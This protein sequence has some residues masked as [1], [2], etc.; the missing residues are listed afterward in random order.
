VK[1]YHHIYGGEATDLGPFSRQETQ[2][3]LVK[4]GIN[5]TLPSDGR[6]DGKLLN[7]IGDRREVLIYSA[8]RKGQFVVTVINR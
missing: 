7:I 1:Q 4:Q 3:W 8:P 2:K 6:G 5:V